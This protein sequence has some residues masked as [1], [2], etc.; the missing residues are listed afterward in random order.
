MDSRW[1]RPI[2]VAVV[3]TATVVVFRRH[4]FSGYT[5]P[6]DFWGKY[7]A[8]P[9]FVSSSVGAGNPFDWTPFSGGGAPLA[10]D[11]QVGLYFPVW[12]L[13]GVLHIPATISVVTLVQIL[14]I[15][16]GAAGV[17][18]LARR[19][20]I[21]LPWAA[22]AAIGYVFFGGFY[23]NAEH[24]DIFRGFA[25][26]PW[27]LWSITIPIDG[28]RRTAIVAF[29]ILMW[30]TGSGAYPGQIVS[31]TLLCALYAGVEL[32]MKP[33]DRRQWLTYGFAFAAA[34]AI[35]AAIVT[36]YLSA[37]SA[38]LLWRP[39]PSTVEQRAIWALRPVDSLGLY[40]SAFSWHFEGTIY[41]WAIGAP[42]LVGLAG[43]RRPALRG[44]PGLVVIGG[45]ALALATLPAWL[46]AGRLL[47][48]IPILD[49]SR[50][51]A[52]DYKA[53]AALALLLLCVVGWQGLFQRPRVAGAAAIGAALAAGVLVAPQHTSIPPTERLPLL[54]L[55][56]AASVS[57]PLVASRAPRLALIALVTLV[58]VDGGRSV[59]D[60]EHESGTRPW[61]VNGDYVVARRER[62]EGARRAR[63]VL[64]API[65]RRPARMPP[66]AP[67]DKA[68]GGT[69]QDAL[70]YYG[71]G[72]YLSDFG[73]TIT[74]ARH[75]IRTNPKLEA[76]MLQS[77]TAWAW[78]CEARLCE[79]GSVN[80]PA[81]PWPET[82]SVRTTSYG[83][84]HITYA[85]ALRVPSLVIENETWFPGWRADD[86]RIR[87]V[88][89]GGALRGWVLPAGTYRFTAEFHPAQRTEQLLLGLLAVAAWLAS[90]SACCRRATIDAKVSSPL[91]A[92]AETQP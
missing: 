6:W 16:F 32:M 22:V 26:L 21:A 50:F 84:D 37:D 36:P 29:P 4:L 58:A 76:L 57:L 91:P 78:P 61:E 52:A 41:Q 20:S 69:E 30:L 12:W 56:L 35:L 7:S 9:A 34:L 31:F 44:H 5:F 64:A 46:P 1:T 17:F 15:P 87:L 51:P 72:Y 74:S 67:L 42:L 92:E 85:V 63:E 73:G 47:A 14:H 79:S 83:V 70:G 24:A 80:L 18:L 49:A 27:L 53:P 65:P 68:P 90:V 59:A 3:V 48:A 13:L 88:S 66:G 23:G 89:V 81:M 62:D 45:A 71:V 40:L 54:L 86:D 28:R 10:V 75:T 2:T 33:S 60:T 11:L 43:L 39:T 38:G 8:G 55:V 77:W 19:R 25:Y 82:T